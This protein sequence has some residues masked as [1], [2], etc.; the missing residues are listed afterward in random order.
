MTVSYA[1]SDGTAEAGADYTET[2]GTLTFA[3]GEMNK[4]V[5]VAIL[6]DD[7]DEGMETL[8]LTL[9]GATGAGIAGGGESATGRIVNT[10]AM[11]K[12]WLA[13]FGRTVAEQVIDVVEARFRTPP[14]Q[15]AEA[16]FAGQALLRQDGGPGQNDVQE[17]ATA[18]VEAESRMAALSDWVRGRIGG[19]DDRGFQSGSGSG[20]GDGR[21][22]TARDLLTGS[23]FALTR[24]A[25]GGGGL[26][27]L[28]GQG[29][30]THF[31]GQDEDLSLDGE[32][33][34]AMLGADW[35]RKDWM[36]GL[37][38]SRSH[39][40]GGYRGEGEGTVETS[41]TGLYPYGRYSLNERVTLWGVTGYGAGT[42][43]L[44]PN[45]PFAEGGTDAGV[46][47]RT[48]TE[49]MMA[50]LG[51]RG[52]MI[53]ASPSGGFE[54]AVNSDGLALRSSS[55]RTAG[56]MAADAAV[57]R[58][59]LGLEGGWRGVTLGGGEL[60]PRFEVG[61]RHDGGDA[62]VGFGL[63]LG[64]GL[65]WSHPAK[66]ISAEI[67]GRG[68][69][70]HESRGFSDWGISGSFSWESGRGTGLGPKLT[71]TQTLGASARGGMDALLGRETLAG[72]AAND[73]GDELENRRLEAT[74]G[75]GF[76]AFGER[77]TST[78]ELGLGLSN[79]LRA[80]RLGWRL[81]LARGRPAALEL[82]LEA[83]R[84]E[85]AGDNVEP[86]HGAGL[87][88]TARW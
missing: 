46:A 84:R 5:S 63:D 82:R 52:V 83:S 34:S 60:R 56:L 14:R 55:E 2:S 49:L 65:A 8:T 37:L 25:P 33:V 69:L 12:A 36:A 85:S 4:T 16:T 26:V 11:P 19:N 79:G 72:L 44:T 47:L 23:S 40:E 30:V 41:V 61:V 28:W 73:N 17:E 45:T 24:N 77:F 43:T 57:F 70:T 1:T 42:L 75:Y 18:R 68:L 78:P 74:F 50:A 21:E 31:G 71:L 58:F 88:L 66:G 38:L 10:D 76:P 81:N 29:A 86:E 22:L 53:E 59:R 51:V 6:D 48:G 64:G 87:R 15:G 13:R 27:S 35:A 32:V 7:H 67:N 80:Y 20:F 54:L 3:P 9:S 62:E 39:G